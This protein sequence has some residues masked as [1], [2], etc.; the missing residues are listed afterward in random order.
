MHGVV[1][2]HPLA[3]KQAMGPVQ[4]DV[5]ADEEDHHLYDKRQRGQRP[6][7]VVIKGYQPVRGGDLKQQRRA[8]NEHADAQEAGDDRNEKPVAEIGHKVALC[9]TTAWPGLQ[10]QNQVRTVNTA[11]TRDRDRHALHD[12]VAD[13]DEKREQFLT[14]V[15]S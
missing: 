1:L 13:L 3:V 15:R 4:H 11:A 14:H 8:D 6:V 10:A 2:P 5:L 7:A 12:G 9:A